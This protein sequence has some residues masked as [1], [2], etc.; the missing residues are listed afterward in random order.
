[1]AEWVGVLAA[2]PSLLDW[3]GQ[4]TERLVPAAVPSLLDWRGHWTERLVPRMRTKSM[5]DSR[6][7]DRARKRSLGSWTSKK[8]GTIALA[9]SGK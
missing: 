1:M 9:A 3:R 2:V 8:I 6:G 4:R 5:S 7:P